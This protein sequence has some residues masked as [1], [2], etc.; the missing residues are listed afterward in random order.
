LLLDYY[1]L[2]I[3]NCQELSLKRYHNSYAEKIKMKK[4]KEENKKAEKNK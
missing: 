2:Q 4:N 3:E 1:I